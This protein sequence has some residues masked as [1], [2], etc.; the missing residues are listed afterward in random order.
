VT[1]LLGKFH[2]DLLK[3]GIVTLFLA[4]KNVPLFRKAL[5]RMLKRFTTPFQASNGGV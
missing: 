3:R 4:F 5:A 1:P 2:P